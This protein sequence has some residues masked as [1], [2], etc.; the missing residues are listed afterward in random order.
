MKLVLDLI[1][2]CSVKSK[3]TCHVKISNSPIVK[4]SVS[5]QG[6]NGI[7]HSNLDLAVVGLA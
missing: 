7:A 1:R 6:H 2:G 5:D 4:C 3:R